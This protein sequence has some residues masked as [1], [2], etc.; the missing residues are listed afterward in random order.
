[1]LTRF[2]GVVAATAALFAF[3]AVADGPDD[4]YVWLEEIDGPKALEW[5]RMENARSLGMLEKDPRFATLREEARTILTS[6]SR[7]PLGEIH[8]GAIYNFWQDETHLRGVWR[9]ASA[10]SYRNGKPEWETLVDF[11]Q[12]ARDENE[13]WVA[14]GIVCLEPEHRHCMVELSRGG[15][16]TSTW[17]EFDTT[18]RRFVPA[19][20][21]L[22]EAKSNLDWFDE[23]TLVVGTDWGAHSLTTSGYARTVKV[24][25]R[26]T[27]LPDAR[28]LFDGETTDVAV[29][30]FI[31][32][33][34]GTPQ[35][36]I[37]RG[38]SFFESEHYYAPGLDTPA[39]LPLPRN[40]EI[41]GVLDGRAIVTLREPWHYGGSVY[42]N[43]AIVAYA[44]SGR[45]GGTRV[46][47]ARHAVGR[48]RGRRR[49][50]ARRAIP[51]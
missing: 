1:M 41:Q 43:G 42:P 50:R 37:V 32:H 19:G 18:T 17:R 16:D 5:A 39:K 35:P 21:A 44:P 8:R 29:R 26:G 10:D 24:W 38:V 3:T 30:P 45:R 7:L 12:L 13:N 40:A 27:P 9:R 49:N 46:R 15:G 20:F 31:D 11:D 2:A 23:D 25:R 14:G 4:P 51:G 36:F 22:P 34:A 33:E 28:T 47:T 6:P 48:G